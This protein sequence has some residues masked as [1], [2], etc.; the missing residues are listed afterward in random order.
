MNLID[1]IIKK[2]KEVETSGKLEEIIEKHV[3]DCLENIVEDSFRWSGEAKKKDEEARKKAQEDLDKA[4]KKRQEEKAKAD[5]KL[6]KEKKKREDAEKALKKIEDDKKAKAA[7]ALRLEQENLKKGD[8][9]KAQDFIKDLEAL[10]TKYEFKS[11]TYRAKQG[12]VTA[13]INNAIAAL[14]GKNNVF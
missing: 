3:V 10:K 8:S 2:V 1:L 14:E 11:G 12:Y 6:A 9:E 5:A 4:N 7:E 13:L